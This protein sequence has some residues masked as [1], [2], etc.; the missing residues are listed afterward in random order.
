MIRIKDP[1]QTDKLSKSALEHIKSFIEDN[2]QD[3]ELDNMR[4]K[5]FSDL[6]NVMDMS[7]KALTE[8]N[9]NKETN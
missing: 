4:K 8:P 5:R 6:L 9:E 1:W 2:I 7:I 3:Q